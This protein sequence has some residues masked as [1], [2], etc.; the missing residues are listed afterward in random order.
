MLGKLAMT[1]FTAL[2][3]LQALTVHQGSDGVATDNPATQAQ[4]RRLEHVKL[5]LRTVGEDRSTDK[6][7]FRTNEDVGGPTSS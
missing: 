4:E 1:T 5:E 2:L 3:G 6:F 7:W